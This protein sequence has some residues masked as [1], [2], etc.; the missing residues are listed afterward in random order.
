MIEA[1]LGVIEYTVVGFSVGLGFSFATGL[2]NKL[3]SK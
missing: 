3:F 1:L 2:V